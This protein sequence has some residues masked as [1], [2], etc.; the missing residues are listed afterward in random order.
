MTTGDCIYFLRRIKFMIKVIKA[1]TV[2]IPYLSFPLWVSSY[3]TWEFWCRSHVYVTNF[4]VISSSN[5]NQLIKTLRL[6]GI[7]EQLFPLT[8]N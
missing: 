4:T 2:S 1:K 3:E 8:Q 6:K 7:Q 5:L